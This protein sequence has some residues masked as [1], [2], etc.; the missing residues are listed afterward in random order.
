MESAVHLAYP[1]LLFKLNILK[2][3]IMKNLKIAQQPS[4]TL[5]H[6]HSHSLPPPPT[7]RKDNREGANS[8]CKQQNCFA[9]DSLFIYD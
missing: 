9:L 1:G 6:S 5:P 4:F 8:Y 2:N 3:S 7:T